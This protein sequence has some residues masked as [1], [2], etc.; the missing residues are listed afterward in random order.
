MGIDFENPMGMD[1]GMTFENRY[2]C[3]Y[4]STHPEPT[5]CKSL[6]RRHVERVC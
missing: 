4:S 2:G 6:L 3:G 5:P 1:I